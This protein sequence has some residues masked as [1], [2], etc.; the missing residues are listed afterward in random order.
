MLTV[1]LEPETARRI[2]QL[3]QVLAT[4]TD[5]LIDQA[6]RDYLE[7]QEDEKLESEQQAF[8]QQRADL[9]K[10]YRGEYV[11]VHNGEVVDHDPDLG[12]LHQRV[13]MRLGE[14]PVL[15]KPVTEAPEGDLVWRHF[16]LE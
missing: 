5:A 12:V 14:T 11:A 1:T 10:H 4:P 3:A 9:M 13:W 15:L 8:E 16:H 7:R 2:E 6:V